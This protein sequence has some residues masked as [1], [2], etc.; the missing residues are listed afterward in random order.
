MAEQITVD[1]RIPDEGYD[2][3]WTAT[4]DKD[5]TGT[6]PS[7]WVRPNFHLHQ[8]NGVADALK[9]S[10]NYYFFTVADRLGIDEL[11]KWADFLGLTSKTNVELLGEMAGQV[12]NPRHVV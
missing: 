12:A 3:P 7:C 9:N 1:E 5:Y 10:C 11:N 6:K 4:I 2:G 8:N